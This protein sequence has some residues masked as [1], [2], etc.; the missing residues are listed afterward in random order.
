MHG[1][2]TPHPTHR[3]TMPCLAVLPIVPQPIE[4]RANNI[5][6]RLNWARHSKQGHRSELYMRSVAQEY[7]QGTWDVVTDDDLALDARVRDADQVVLLWT[8]AIGF[9]TEQVERRVLAARKGSGDVLVVNG[10]RRQFVLT[11]ER[12]RAMRTRRL[13]ERYWVGET[14]LTAALLISAVPL[15]VFDLLRRRT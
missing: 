15:M 8:D 9:G 3:R 4:A 7:G 6:A 13:L 11:P 12:L 1:T 5:I 10:R 2:N 14:V